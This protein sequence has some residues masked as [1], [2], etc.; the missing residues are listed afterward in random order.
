MKIKRYF[1]QKT[2]LRSTNLRTWNKFIGKKTKQQQMCFIIGIAVFKMLKIGIVK[3]IM[4]RC[5][6]FWIILMLILWCMLSGESTTYISLLTIT[7]I[8]IFYLCIITR[9]WTTFVLWKLVLFVI[10]RLIVVTNVSF[11]HGIRQMRDCYVETT[12]LW[13]QKVMF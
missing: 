13:K 7:M 11:K 12:N 6:H 5:L 1:W 2:H 3:N 10:I 8:L 4:K 9:Q